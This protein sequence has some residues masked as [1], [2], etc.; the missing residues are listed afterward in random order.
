MRTT[1]FHQSPHGFMHPGSSSGSKFS[2][3]VWQV[4]AF[5]PS[6]GNSD[7]PFLPHPS[8]ASPLQDPCTF[9]PYFPP[10]PLWGCKREICV[11]FFSFE[12][13]EK[14][15]RPKAIRATSFTS[16]LLKLKRLYTRNVSNIRVTDLSSLRPCYPALS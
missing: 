6:Q 16:L 9:P 10:E 2:A 1:L 8:S 13:H 15:N 7:T 11:Y 5:L 4:Y 12:R 14:I 3:Q